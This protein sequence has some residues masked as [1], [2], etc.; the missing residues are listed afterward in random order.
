[1]T[2]YAPVDPEIQWHDLDFEEQMALAR[3]GGP[4]EWS[5]LMNP[6]WTVPEFVR[7]VSD[8]IK[9]EIEYAVANRDGGL[10]VISLPPGHNK[11]YMSSINTPEWFIEK[12][13]DKRVA[14]ISYGHAKAVEWGEDIRNHVRDNPD[15]FTVSLSKDTQS[16]SRFKTQ[17]GG[18]I[19]C[20]GIG[21]PL[22]GFRAHLIDID[23]PVKDDEE[24][25]SPIMREKHWQWFRKVAL[26]RRW[27][28]AT[29][30]IVMTRWHEDDLV[31]RIHQ[32]Y[33][34][35]RAL[36]DEGDLPRL[37]EIRIPCEAEENDP[38]GREVGQL[39]WPEAG[40]DARWATQTKRILGNQTWVSMYQQRP[41]PEGGSVFRR[42]DFRYFYHASDGSYTLIH[43]DGSE[44]KIQPTSCWKL[45]T[46]DTA[47]KDKTV[48]DWTVI[49]TLAVTRKRQVL[50]L[51]VTRERIPI[52]DQLPLI[53][54][55]KLKYKPRHVCVEDASSGTGIILEARREGL[56]FKP[57]KVIKNKVSRA[58]PAAA[59]TEQHAA[60]FLRDAPWLEDF[61]NEL[62]GFPN[63]LHDD[64][65]DAY[66]HAIN[67]LA[68]QG[69]RERTPPVLKKQTTGMAGGS[70]SP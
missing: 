54:A 62:M 63:A 68:N 2:V 66:A 31:G 15:K 27:P 61:E 1:M 12:W 28:E 38:L 52:P 5:K 59:F 22:T 33:K 69:E 40:Y 20:T 51:N 65:V 17:S 34:E 8:I 39:L 55:L 35:A 36:G 16:K 29:T 4:A 41:S 13:Q 7:G 6:Q 60:F 67:E 9:R 48:N 46:V 25:Q 30:L 14:V 58:A 26:T 32:L 18:A 19:F 21:G 11:S 53:R 37:T 10:L 42:Q 43:G 49:I 57:I 3:A 56:M 24:A 50:I 64:Q 44:E 70:W 47:M 45:Q 23:D